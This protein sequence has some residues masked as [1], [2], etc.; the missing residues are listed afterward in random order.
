MEISLG[1]LRRAIGPIGWLAHLPEL[2]RTPLT[3]VASSTTG[4]VAV[5]ALGLA[6]AAG[7]AAPPDVPRPR[8]ESAAHVAELGTSPGSTTGGSTA[9]GDHAEQTT[10][11]TKATST[12]LNS[13]GHTE[14]LLPP[15]ASTT[16]TTTAATTT[17]I[18]TTIDHDQAGP[19]GHGAVSH[20]ADDSTPSPASTLPPV[21][22][23]LPPA[24]I[25]ATTPTT[26]PVTT[27]ATTTAPTTTTTTPPGGQTNA[28]NDTASGHDDKWITIHVLQ[29]DTFGGS[30]VNILT[31]AVV[32]DP[33]HGS[34]LVSGLNVVYRSDHNFRGTDTF[35]YS[36]CSLAGS[37]DQAT[38]DGD[39]H[40]LTPE[41]QRRMLP[42]TRCT[43]GSRSSPKDQSVVPAL[44][45]RPL[46]RV[47]VPITAWLWA[48][49]AT[50][51]ADGDPN[52]RG[53]DP[54][55]ITGRIAAGPQRRSAPRSSSP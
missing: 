26:V 16:T 46:P 47:N 54:L 18:K 4:I 44:N 38:V 17:T 5:G 40:A 49:R 48:M 34:A 15:V 30:S 27:P 51:S 45:T 14:A 12:T 53:S 23:T 43:S 41:S 9:T 50:F 20:R 28:V 25:P 13:A 7:A 22:T 31:L 3:A 8:H 10:P 52:K 36:I 19:L 35:V 32:D 29:N 39:H 11:N 2:I 33:A 42:V 21:L 37:C 55:E 24:T 1:R 6:T